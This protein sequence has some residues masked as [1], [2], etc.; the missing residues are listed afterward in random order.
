MN[1][2]GPYTMNIAHNPSTVPLP[3]SR[4]SQG[5]EV[6]AGSQML[7]V[8]GQVGTDAHGNTPTDAAGQARVIWR[9]ISAILASASMAPTDIIKINT[10]LLDECDAAAAAAARREEIGEHAPAATLVVVSKLM[11]PEWCMEI[12]VVAARAA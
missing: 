6:S 10:Y 3:T 12:E 4:F 8:S 5:M 7:F 2:K 9:N 11:R 1:E